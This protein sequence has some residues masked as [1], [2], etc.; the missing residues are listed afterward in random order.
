MMLRINEN[1][2]SGGR[3]EWGDRGGRG[4]RGL[5]LSVL[6]FTAIGS[7]ANGA[8]GHGIFFVLT[9]QHGF[10]DRLNLFFAL[11]MYVPY[12]PAA[13]FAGKVSRVFGER[14][15]L[16]AAVLVMTVCA[17]FL[18][19]DSS[20]ISC[21]VVAPLYTMCAGFQWPI[22]ESY[23]TAGRHGSKMRQTIGIW[24]ITWATTI[25]FGLWAVGLLLARSG[26]L[27]G[28][29][30]ISH[31]VSFVIVRWW[32]G[33]VR[34]HDREVGEAHLGPE[35]GALLKSCQSL[36]FM[37]YVLGYALTPLLPGVWKALEVDLGR[38]ALW[39]SAW[40]VARI[41]PFTV[42]YI[43]VNWHGK[44][45]VPIVASCLLLG[46]FGLALSGLSGGMVVTGLVCFGLGHAM[47]YY[48]A[49]YYRMAVGHAQVESGGT[50]EA[51]IGLGYSVGPAVALVGEA[52]WVG[53]PQGGILAGVSVLVVIAG[54][55]AVRPYLGRRH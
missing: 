10:S 47:I 45:R 49:L 37:S 4:E 34:V 9:E 11:A 54:V 3:G 43:F 17:G 18:V 1:S 55:F 41:V 53:N 39:S 31:G 15:V 5:F 50:H 13:L 14:G 26:V 12:V 44:W 51:L 22:V 21:W 8:I 38:G 32:P 33:R 30:A 2:E 29:I 46:G 16:T 7:F 48:A 25:C 20:V 35:Y 19:W 27:F 24:N 42:M 52:V 23:L 6:V 28:L 40:L 36:L